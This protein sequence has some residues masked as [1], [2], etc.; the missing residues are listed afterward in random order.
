MLF[1]F[2]RRFLILHKGISIQASRDTF[3]EGKNS[4]YLHGF[5]DRNKSVILK[6]HNITAF[7]SPM[8]AQSHSAHRPIY[9]KCTLS[10]SKHSEILR[11]I[12][13]QYLSVYVGNLHISLRPFGCML[14]L[15]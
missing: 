10:A 5:F 8:H 14:Q 1:V 2:V 15:T 6:G 4:L 13:V 9:Y 11:L 12:V 7:L 3:G